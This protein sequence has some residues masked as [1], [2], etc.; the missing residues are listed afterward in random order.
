MESMVTLRHP[1]IVPVIGSCEA[2]D[3]FCII[4]EHMYG[5]T[6]H[7][8]IYECDN[9]IELDWPPKLEVM[10]GVAKGLEYMHKKGVMH[11]GIKR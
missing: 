6:L 7:D 10:Y 1:N 9:Y 5:G 2:N 3:Q 8:L 4:M 11:L